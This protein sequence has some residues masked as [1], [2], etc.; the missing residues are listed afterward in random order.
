M[1]VTTNPLGVNYLAVHALRSRNGIN[2]YEQQSRLQKCI[3]THTKVVSHFRELIRWN[4]TY[5]VGGVEINPNVGGMDHA[6]Y[7]SI[8]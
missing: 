5:P 8:A 4:Q 3:R 1:R 6:E 2:S 7:E